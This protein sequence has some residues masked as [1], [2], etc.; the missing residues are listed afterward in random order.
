MLSTLSANFIGNIGARKLHSVVF[1]DGRCKLDKIKPENRVEFSAL[2]DGLNY[3]GN[4]RRIC[5]LRN[6]H[7]KYEDH[8][9][10]KAVI[11]AIVPTALGTKNLT[12]L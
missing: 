4:G 11:L 12:H 5:T 9:N 10:D 8:N 3:P 2:E 1:A 7:Q 6:L